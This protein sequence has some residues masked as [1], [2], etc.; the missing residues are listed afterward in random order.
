MLRVQCQQLHVGE[1]RRRGGVE[2]F[3]SLAAL[4]VPMRG[5]RLRGCGRKAGARLGA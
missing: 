3:V 2:G 5:L 1:P 4:F